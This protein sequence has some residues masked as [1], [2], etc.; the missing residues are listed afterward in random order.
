MKKVS[1]IMPVYNSGQYLCSSLESVANQSFPLNELELIAVDDFSTDSS[2]KVLK[3][4][5][6]RA[7]FSMRLIGSNKN[8]GASADVLLLMSSGNFDAINWK[9]ELIKG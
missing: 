5:K 1:I 4:Y 7:P 3:D 6:L 2:L 8:K 9:E